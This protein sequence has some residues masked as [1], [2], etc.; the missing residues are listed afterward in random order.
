MTKF[1]QSWYDT[2]TKKAIQ[3][4]VAAVSDESGTKR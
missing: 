4:F 1:L 2:L 3:A